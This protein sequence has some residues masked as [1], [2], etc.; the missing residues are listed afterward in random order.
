[1]RCALRFKGDRLA[2]PARDGENGFALSEV[3]R[4]LVHQRD[5]REA[6]ARKPQ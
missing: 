5:N 2:T 6:L 3:R 4:Q 1:M